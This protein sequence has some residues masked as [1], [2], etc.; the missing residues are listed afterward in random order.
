MKT[1]SFLPP[2]SWMQKNN[3]AKWK[4]FVHAYLACI[5][6]TDEQLG[7]VLDALDAGPHADNTIIVFYSDQGFIWREIALVEVLLWER[8]T[9]VPMI[10]STPGGLKS[11]LSP[12]GRIAEHLPT[13]VEL[14]GLG[15][16]PDN[17]EGVSLKALL[18]NPGSH[19]NIRPS[20]RSCRT[21]TP[22]APSDG[23][24]SATPT[25]ARSF[26]TTKSTLT[27]GPIWQMIPGRKK[28]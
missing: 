24:T 12:D 28:R 25:A 21:T 23:V 19:G 8:S 6:W 5:R 13:L 1:W 9:R 27:S 17:L 26:T 18:N 20:P 22:S 14:C 4:E 10:I 16:G 15:D 2:H 11:Q 7:R 3:N